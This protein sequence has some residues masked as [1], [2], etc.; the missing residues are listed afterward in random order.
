MRIDSF[1]SPPNFYGRSEVMVRGDAEYFP[2]F[3]GSG[4]MRLVDWLKAPPPPGANAEDHKEVRRYF[5][6]TV[7]LQVCYEPRC[8]PATPYLN[9]T[10]ILS[11]PA[12]R[13]R[14]STAVMRRTRGACAR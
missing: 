2:T 8:N 4:E 6:K 3:R 9:V 13:M 11:C 12:S 7:A 10:D 5:E 14:L 1:Q